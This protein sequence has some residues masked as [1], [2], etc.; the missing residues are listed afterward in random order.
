[1]MIIDFVR[2]IACMVASHLPP[3]W[4]LS[5]SDE[6]PVKPYD[7]FGAPAR[8]ELAQKVLQSYCPDLVLDFMFRHHQAAAACS[9]LLSANAATVDGAKPQPGK[10]R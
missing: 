6:I 4:L 8:Y 7:I 2:D 3:L 10:S 5:G 9:L 1:M